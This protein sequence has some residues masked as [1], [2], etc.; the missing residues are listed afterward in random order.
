[1]TVVR[2]I[3]ALTMRLRI[4]P[5]IDA[6]VAP[7]SLQRS[8]LLRPDVPPVAAERVVGLVRQAAVRV[9]VRPQAVRAYV[10]G[11][12]TGTTCAPDELR[13]LR[14]IVL[15]LHGGAWVV[16]RAHEERGGSATAVTLAPVSVVHVIPV[17]RLTV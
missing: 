15:A 12:A 14:R 6:P 5:A 10:F 3:S 4:A 2:Y 1:V 16:G 17:P 11:G 13:S 7:A 8:A 9:G